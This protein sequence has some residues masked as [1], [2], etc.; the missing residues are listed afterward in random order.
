MSE[1]RF[2]TL[3]IAVAAAFTGFFSFVVLPPLFVDPD[4]LGAFASGFVNPYASGY[5]A[6][7][8]SCWLILGI[9]V[10]YEARAMGTRHGW[11]CLVIG[12]IPGVAVGFAAYLLLRHAQLNNAPSHGR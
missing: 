3:L 2:R 11:V 8:I 4:I 1:R 5:S 10:L 12:I 7:V 6:D 9:W